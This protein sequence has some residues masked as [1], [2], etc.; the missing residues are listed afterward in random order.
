MGFFDTIGKIAGIASV[1]PGPHQAVTAPIALASSV[2]SAATGGGGGG[3]EGGGV[4]GG[5][6][7]LGGLTDL[8]RIYGGA[9]AGIGSLTQ[10][11][12]L[13]REALEAQR[14]GLQFARDRVAE[15]A[16]FRSVALRDLTGDLPL[17]PELGGVYS[18]PT[19]PFSRSA[20]SL[21]S[22]LPM[23]GPQE[24]ADL[25]REAV[26]PLPQLSDREIDRLMASEER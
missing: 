5:G 3:V 20:P 26:A 11:R 21:N 14:E 19:N 24:S 25:P 18:D 22:L 7:F 17:A 6:G 13:S 8:A 1:I 16:P 9:I 12:R 2:A 4:E 15:T 10:G 23:L